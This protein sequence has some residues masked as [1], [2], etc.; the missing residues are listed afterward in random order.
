M[1]AR[2]FSP[3]WEAEVMRVV[4]ND[5]RLQELRYEDL[6]YV[7]VFLWRLFLLELGFL[8]ELSNQISQLLGK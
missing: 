1:R 7:H 2:F 3:H 6:K 8:I 5:M 4:K